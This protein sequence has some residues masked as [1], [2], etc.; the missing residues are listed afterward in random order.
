MEK[1]LEFADLFEEQGIQVLVNGKDA[2]TVETEF[3]EKVKRI[4]GYLWMGGGL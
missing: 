4:S 1:A 2:I 3:K